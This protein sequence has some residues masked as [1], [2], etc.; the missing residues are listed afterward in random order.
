[1]WATYLS[2]LISRYSLIQSVQPGDFFRNIFSKYY[3][4][5]VCACVCEGV[6]IVTFM[7]FSRLKNTDEIFFE[8]M[9]ERQ[10]VE[11]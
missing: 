11:L 9:T 3:E 6:S 10:M 4:M 8:R 7:F 5:R 1:M 2:L